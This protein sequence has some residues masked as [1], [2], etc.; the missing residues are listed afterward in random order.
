MDEVLPAQTVTGRPLNRRLMHLIRRGHLYLGLFLFPW[1]VL[2][3]VTAFLFNHPTAFSDQPTKSFSSNS[4]VGTPLEKRLSPNEQADQLVAK[5][6][7]EKKPITPFERVSEAKY[8]RDFAFATIKA[9]GQTV[10]VLID[11]KHGHGTVRSAPDKPKVEVRQAPFV[12]SSPTSSKRES[13][14]VAPASPERY[15]INYPIRENIEASIPKILEEQRFPSGPVTVTSVPDVVFGLFAEG[16]TWQASYNPLTGQLS[17]TITSETSKPELS[18]RRFLTRLHLL[19]GYPSETNARWFWAII[20]DLMAFVML[21]WG[22]SGLLMWWQIKA[23]RRIGFVVL[24]TS[25]ISAAAL[26]V[27]LYQSLTS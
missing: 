10:S 27:A 20:V 11:L 15:F 12:Q 23:T 25:A 8:N 5:L 17:A 21:F 3:G 4:L 7:E 2:Y 13:R 6:N 26:G 19:H 18:A 14:S 9:E 24:L 16:E 22:F 1:A